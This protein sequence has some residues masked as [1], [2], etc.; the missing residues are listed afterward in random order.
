MIS[1]SV[2]WMTTA[3]TMMIRLPTMSAARA[4]RPRASSSRVSAPH[5]SISIGRSSF[6]VLVSDRPTAH[7]SAGGAGTAGAERRPR[8]I[9][10]GRCIS[11]RSASRI[12]GRCTLTTTSRPPARWARWTRAIEAA[13]RG[14]VLGLGEQLGD[15]PPRSGHPPRPDRTRRTRRQGH[16]LSSLRRDVQR[17]GC[18]DHLPR[19][20][21]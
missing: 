10:R 12:P 20:A 2:E 7:R 3:T 9:R 4:G 5:G 18:A 16:R 19:P 15:G 17:G 14:Q 21:G 11:R 1:R 6:A 13:R 8:S